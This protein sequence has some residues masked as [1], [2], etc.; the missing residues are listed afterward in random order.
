[1][2]LS[3]MSSL[4]P[5]PPGNDKTLL[6]RV[7]DA[8]LPLINLVFLLLMFFLVAGQLSD[9]QLPDLPG[10]ADSG[11]SDAPR[12]DL[13]VKSVDQWTVGGDPVDRDGLAQALPAGETGQVLRVAVDRNL[14]MAELETVFQALEDVGHGEIL[15]LTEPGK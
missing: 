9:D 7:E 13:V 10:V 14:S 5:A 12:A 2:K 15:L 1:M 11:N 6:E 8:L 4:L 3:P